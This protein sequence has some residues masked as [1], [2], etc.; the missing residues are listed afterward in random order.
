MRFGAC[1]RCNSQLH[2]GSL[3]IC[4]N[5]GWFES[6]NQV[7]ARIAAENK[8]IKIMVGT[9]VTLLLVA[10]HML[11]WGSHAYSIPGL[12]L[13]QWT[14]MLSVQG[15]DE[16]AQACVELGKFSC[17]RTAYIENFQ[18]NRTPEPLAKLAR[19][20][21]RLQETQAAAVTFDSYFKNGGKDGEAAILYGQILEQ[22]GQDNEAIRFYQLSI[23]ARPDQLPIAATGA[24][25]RIFM[26]QGRYEEAFTLLTEFQGSAGNAKGYLN[27]ELGQVTQALAYY[28]IKPKNPTKKG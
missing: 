22:A 21:V 23:T 8:T 2:T 20:Q 3:S 15:Y 14:G 13:G 17:A 16:L 1:P 6:S 9:A 19:L 27:T 24:L 10:A 11:N 7:S 25:A 18:K 5:C 26:K 28:K 4:Q 12:K